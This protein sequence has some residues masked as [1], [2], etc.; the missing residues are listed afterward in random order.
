MPKLLI[1]GAGQYGMVA[2]EI[3]ESMNRF[4]K[5]DF[6][7]DNNPIAVGKL[8]E[9]EKFKSEYDSAAVAIGNSELR[10][11]YIEK[12]KAAGYILPALIHDR[13]YVSHTASISEGCFIEAMTVINT[14]A[15]IGT[16]CIISAGAIVNHNAVVEIGCHLDCGTIVKARVNIPANT[17]TDYGQIIG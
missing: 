5:I 9:Y 12:L 8:N 2:K 16:G 11:D 3:A 10:L 15:N 4:E 13:A 17:K 6:L 14:E 7:D 1:L